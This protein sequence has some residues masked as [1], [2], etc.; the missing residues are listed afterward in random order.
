MTVRS[1]SIFTSSSDSL[2]YTRLPSAPGMSGS[3]GTEP[4]S[5]NVRAASSWRSPL[6]VRTDRC[7]AS[8]NVASPSMTS[9][10][11]L[12]ASVR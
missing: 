10:R 8:T 12:S 7:V 9:M 6:A 1:G 4:V 11:G 5:M 3:A 2:V